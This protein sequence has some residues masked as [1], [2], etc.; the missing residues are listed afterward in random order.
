MIG[1]GLYLFNI[2][3]PKPKKFMAEDDMSMNHLWKMFTMNNCLIKS[4]LEKIK[5]QI[6][7]C[8]KCF[9]G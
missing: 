5:E 8:C 7:D 3:F 1:E 9:K 2:P 6:I 4:E